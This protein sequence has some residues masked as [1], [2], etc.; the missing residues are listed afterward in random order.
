MK[1]PGHEACHTTGKKA[2]L[3]QLWVMNMDCEAQ[4]RPIKGYHD[5]LL[6]LYKQ[7]WENYK[8]KRLEH[9]EMQTELNQHQEQSRDV[10]G[11][12][13]AHTAGAHQ[14]LGRNELRA[15]LM[16]H[17]ADTARETRRHADECFAQ[18]SATGGV[19]DHWTAGEVNE[20]VL[21][22]RAINDQQ[23]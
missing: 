17:L 5:D 23:T 12:R 21:A 13:S 15:R 2:E 7:A 1:G 20:H 10:P 19:E 3:E 9:G 8:I 16:E 14:Y 22:A 11:G 6:S 18:G 4:I